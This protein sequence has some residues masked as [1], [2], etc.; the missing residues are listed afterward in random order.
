MGALPSAAGN[1]V[2]NK[3]SA[4]PTNHPLI[5]ISDLALA[6]V[7]FLRSRVVLLVSRQVGGLSDHVNDCHSD[8]YGDDDESGDG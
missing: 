6:V 5:G 8:Y 4:D 1:D 7:V 3:F 2:V